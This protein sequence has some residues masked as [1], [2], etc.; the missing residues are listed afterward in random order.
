MP[1][2][3]REVAATGEGLIVTKR[4][5][6]V[7]HLVPILPRPERIFGALK[8]ITEIVDPNDDLNS[9]LDEADLRAW[10]ESLERKAATLE[11]SFK[12]AAKR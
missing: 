6:R 9:A 4:G 11:E 12:K 1:N 5:K 3:A 7:A 10:E 8:D 2:A